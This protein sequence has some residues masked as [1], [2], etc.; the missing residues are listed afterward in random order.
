MPSGKCY[1][2]CCG[3][4][5]AAIGSRFPPEMGP[6]NGPK[7]SSS[8]RLPDSRVNKGLR[9][10]LRRT[11]DRPLADALHTHI[12]NSSGRT[13]LMALLHTGDRICAPCG[14]MNNRH[15]PKC[16]ADEFVEVIS[17]Y[18]RR[19]AIEDSILVDCEQA[20]MG[21]MRTQLLKWSLA[22]TA[23]TFHR[24]VWPIGGES[25]LPP[26]QS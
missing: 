2:R 22:I 14:G 12:L 24:Y 1:W 7:S 25:K 21:E 10:L 19:Q 23:T 26:E 20:P 16:T 17:V 4:G 8:R 6:S 5:C 18:T 15:Q 9:R 13:R 11:G 3:G